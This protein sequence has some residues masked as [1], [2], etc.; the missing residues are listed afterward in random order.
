MPPLSSPRNGP[1]QRSV[2]F[3]KGKLPDAV[4]YIPQVEDS[5]TRSHQKPI[6]GSRRLPARPYPQKS[7]GIL[8]QGP[9]IHRPQHPRKKGKSFGIRL[10]VQPKDKTC[11]TVR[12]R[13][14]IGRRPLPWLERI[15]TTQRTV[16]GPA[17]T[18]AWCG[19]QPSIETVPE[20]WVPYAHRKSHQKLRGERCNPSPRLEA[21]PEGVGKRPG[22]SYAYQALRRR[23]TSDACPR[24][25]A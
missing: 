19:R 18:T 4:I 2:G 14:G 1:P 22:A 13:G 8:S 10:P 25:E 17:R 11:E 21:P 20:I 12:S 3:R 7:D 16:K 15:S 23:A 6:S 24:R 5:Q 9:I